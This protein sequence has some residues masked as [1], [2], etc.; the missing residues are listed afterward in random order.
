MTFYRLDKNGKIKDSSKFK[1]ALDC[2][3]TDKNIVRTF[4]G[5]L[6]FEEEIKKEEYLQAENE[7]Y[8]NIKINTQIEEKKQRL[9]ELT[10]D[11]TQAQAGLIINNIEEKKSEFRVLLNEIRV[12]QGKE[13]REKK[14]D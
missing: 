7:F 6:V 9:E 11:L 4:E 10:K 3:E 1:Y 14:E 8:N 13:P 5:Q 12:L 2:L